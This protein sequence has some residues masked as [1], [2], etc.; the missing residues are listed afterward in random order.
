MCIRTAVAPPSTTSLTVF[1]MSISPGIGP[2]LIPWSMGTMTA[3]PL[4]LS[5]IL[6][7]LMFLPN[8]SLTVLRANTGHYIPFAEENP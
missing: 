6:S 3:L 4:C 7:I 8:I 5:M 2:A 1:F